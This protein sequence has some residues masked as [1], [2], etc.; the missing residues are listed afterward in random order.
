MGSPAAQRAF[1]PA[2]AVAQA[3]PRD[4]GILRDV[5]HLSLEALTAHSG[6]TM[7]VRV[8]VARRGV[9]ILCA[10]GRPCGE[11]KW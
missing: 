7:L 9:R 1:L 2:A 5:H 6:D 4:V 8:H 3:A 10:D 11:P